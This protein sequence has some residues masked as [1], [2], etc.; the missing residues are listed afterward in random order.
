ME[1][2]HI[3]EDPITCVEVVAVVQIILHRIIG[4]NRGHIANHLLGDR[5]VDV[6]PDRVGHLDV[7]AEVRLAQNTVLVGLVVARPH[8]HPAALVRVVRALDDGVV[9]DAVPIGVNRNTPIVEGN[10][11]HTGIRRLGDAGLEGRGNAVT[12]LG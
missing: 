6:G 1:A 5:N 12:V 4:R 11:D 10:V 9:L 2:V 8:D 3:L 7:V